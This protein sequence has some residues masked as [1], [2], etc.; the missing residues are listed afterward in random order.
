M[1]D[2]TGGR[3]KRF[4]IKGWHVVMALI[5]LV[6]GLLGL[7]VALGRRAMRQRLA[8]LRAA[9][10]PTSFAELDEHNKLPEGAPNAADV[11]LR[12]FAAFMPP[13]DEVNV[14]ILGTAELPGRG[15][16][17]PEPMR[18][19]VSACLTGNRQCLS[20]LHEGAGIADCRYGWDWRTSAA[21]LPDMREVRSCVR[22]LELDAVWHAHTGDANAVLTSLED[23]LRLADSLRREPA[24]IAYLMRVGSTAAMLGGL[25][26]S[27][28]VT[29][30]TDVQLRRLHEALTA[31]GEALDLTQPIAGEQCYL[32][33][34]CRDPS[35]VN[36]PAPSRI[37]RLL[38]GLR[39]RGLVDS[40][41]YM[42]DCIQASKLPPVQRLPK[43]R[44]ASQKVEDLSI[45]HVLIKIM[46]PAMGR[47]GELDT[48]LRAHLD[49]AR[50]ALT[51][52]RYR[53]ATGKLPERLEELVPECFAQ[54]P[55]DP[56]DGRPLRYQRRE[57]GYLLYSVMDDGQDNGGR[58][59]KDIR[60]GEPYDW[61]FIV[62]R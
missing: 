49:L 2:D 59:R 34:V 33:E 6:A 1:N 17:L 7:H 61:C 3:N 10:Y 37:L 18:K 32:I 29:T 60:R 56:F 14:P 9:G 22:L 42:A 39:A 35:F 47:I 46:S 43:L 15:L 11:Y 55:I 16:P 52:E 38:P 62:T 57:S 45:F 8:A 13:A 21:G 48:R 24:L 20:L 25:E 19:A 28:S 27:L 12:A 50:T 40:L 31:A 23:G 54:V 26:Q 41:D 5:V 4:A 53:L 58:E 44:E 51:L 30:F 36:V